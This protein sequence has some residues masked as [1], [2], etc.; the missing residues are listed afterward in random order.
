M[1][2]YFNTGLFKSGITYGIKISRYENEIIMSVT[3]ISDPKIKKIFRWDVRSK[4]PCNEGRIGLRHMYTRS[5]RYKNFKVWKI[6]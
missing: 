1:P 4:S 2:D 6:K 5:A 3:T